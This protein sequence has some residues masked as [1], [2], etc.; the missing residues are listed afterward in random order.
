MTDYARDAAAVRGATDRLMA[1][2]SRLDETAV[3]EPSLLPGWTRGHV[4]AHLARNADALVNLLT[5][6]RTGEPTP[7]YESEDARDREIEEAASRPL[8]VHVDDLRTS[9]FRFHAA[10][11][12]LP[13]DR[14]PYE[15]TMRRGVVEQ[16]GRLPFRRLAEV[17]LHHVDLGVGYTLSDLPAAFVEQE[18]D[19]LA[20]ERFA[21]HPDIPPLLLVSG[22]GG[23]VRRT[24]RAGGDEPP[25]TVEGSPAAL[26][27]WLSGRTDGADLSCAEA[28]LP[29]LPPLG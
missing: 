20:G 1:S 8:P 13:A 14:R 19:F 11:A 24:G 28:P 9:A 7:M 18:L 2:V 23:R 12:A 4:L 22:D 25:L 3:T 29:T 10:A 5:W 27:G 21:G 26:L 16:A 17:E 6:A 15:V